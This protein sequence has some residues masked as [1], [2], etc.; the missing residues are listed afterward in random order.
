MT[1]AIQSQEVTS[2]TVV[3]KTLHSQCQL[4]LMFSWLLEDIDDPILSVECDTKN[5]EAGLE[6]ARLQFLPLSNLLIL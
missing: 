5:E 2:H 6:M 4:G 3:A 1:F